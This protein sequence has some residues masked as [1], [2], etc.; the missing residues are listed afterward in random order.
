MLMDPE[1]PTDW[2]N[3]S[4]GEI[5]RSLETGEKYS[6]D[7]LAGLSGT[8]KGNVYTWISDLRRSGMKI[9]M[10]QGKYFVRKTN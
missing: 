3:A 9:E 1:K 4:P 10:N 6:A 2:R 5:K 8:T 7:Q